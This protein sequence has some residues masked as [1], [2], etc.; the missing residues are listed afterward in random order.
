MQG[1]Y[2]CIIIHRYYTA[3]D[4][5]CLYS[6]TYVLVQVHA[7]WIFLQVLLASVITGLRWSF[8]QLTLQ[9]EELGVCRVG[10]FN[11]LLLGKPPRIN[12]AIIITFLM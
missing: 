11:T 2:I 6:N 4:V 5:L 3:V 9:K 12:C 8:A 1:R 10:V 7:E